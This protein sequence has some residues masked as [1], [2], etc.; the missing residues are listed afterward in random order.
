M[1]RRGQLRFARRGT[2]AF[3]L[4]SK[5][6]RVLADLRE[7]AEGGQERPLTIK[8]VRQVESAYFN[9]QRPTQQVW[10]G[11]CPRGAVITLCS[12]ILRMYIEN[13]TGE[14]C[15]CVRFATPYPQSHFKY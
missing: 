3:L 9:K 11:G 10:G 15:A 2:D 4:L 1:Q 12:F 13:H 6:D 14:G 8:E 5:I 7:T